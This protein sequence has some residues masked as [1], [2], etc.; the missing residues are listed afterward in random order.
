[1]VLSL[2]L[3][4]IS[5]FVLYYGAEKVLNSAESVGAFLGLSP[6]LIGFFI[7]GFGTS[8]PELF[9]SHLSSFRGEDS[10]SFGNIIGSNIANLSL[11]M[12]ISGVFTTLKIYKK[13]IL[14]KIIFHLVITC[15][16]GHFLTKEFFNLK[17]SLFLLMTFLLYIIKVF[18]DMKKEKNELTA[19]KGK[20]SFKDVIF[21]ILGFGLLYSGGEL[22]VYSGKDLGSH[23]GIPTYILSVIV[24]ALGTSF[25]ELMTCIVS[26]KN[27]KDIDIISGNL[28]GSNIFNISF[29]MGTLGIHNIK[30][31]D[32]Y[33][34]DIYIM[35]FL[36]I[37]L[38]VLYLFKKN[39]GRLSGVCFLAVY[40]CSVL[41][42]IGVI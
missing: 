24:V 22:L 10:I 14:E 38:L 41:R 28:I 20:F 7:V 15:M 1:M 33:R 29:V 23:L 34:E 30:L 27:N 18:R 11:V 17:T 19:S 6:L 32:S 21:L 25:P 40:L 16:F 31:L 2:I 4:F 13:K 36:A 26:I 8:L 9:V 12:G 5:L 42:W 37:F 3:L 35:I 39:F